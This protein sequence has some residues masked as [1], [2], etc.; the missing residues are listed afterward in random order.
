MPKVKKE[1]ERNALASG[2]MHKGLQIKGR[3]WI[4]NE[5]RTYL[6]WGRIVLL[7]R[8]GEHG[9]VSAAAKSMQ[10]SFSHAWHL[11]EDMNALSPQPL[12]EKQ[13]GGRRGGG[14]W[15]TDAGR[16]AIDDFFRLVG[17]FQG[18]IEHERL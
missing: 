14:A 16:Q 13:A 9:S 11:V 3:L 17:R 4:E 2:Q 10:M 15:L 6:S 18:W 1:N 12:V 7:E 5:G 8:I